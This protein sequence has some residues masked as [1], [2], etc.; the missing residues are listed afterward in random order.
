MS[1]VSCVTKEFPVDGSI[2]SATKQV[3]NVTKI[4]YHEPLGNGDVH[5]CD[6]HHSDGVVQR[7]FRPD[8][9]E[10]EKEN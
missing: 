6:V 7:I 2:Y 10:F 1:K 3:A 4:D 9:I 8:F 5:Y